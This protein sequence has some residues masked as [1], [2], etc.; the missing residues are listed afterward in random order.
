MGAY[1]QDTGRKGEEIAVEFL[2]ERGFHILERNWRFG[3]SEV[4]II[5]SHSTRLH[6]VEVKTRSGLRFGYPE[7]SISRLKMKQLK[8]AAAA[9]QYRHPQWKYIQFNALSVVLQGERILEIRFFE[10]IYH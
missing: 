1:K 4:D 3:R 8:I 6:L 10:D 9:Y 5:A 7:E 2:R